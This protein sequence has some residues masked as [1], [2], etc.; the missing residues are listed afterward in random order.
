MAN[1]LLYQPTDVK[2]QNGHINITKFCKSATVKEILNGNF[3]LEIELVY[4]PLLWNAIERESIIYA[5]THRGKPLTFRLKHLNKDNKTMKLT[6]RHIFWDLG[7]DLIEDI[8]VKSMTGDQA[9]KYILSNGQSENLWTGE[10]NIL[11]VRNCRI[12]REYKLDAL[13][14][15]DDN[16]FKNRWGGELTIDDFHIAIDKLRGNQDP[17]RIKWGKDIK[18]FTFYEDYS[19]ICTRAM[20]MGFDGLM[21]PE[22]Y[23][24]SPL[25]DKYSMVYIKKYKFEDIKLIKEDDANAT[26]EEGAFASPDE[27]YRE[28][29]RRVTEDI[30]GKQHLDE[31]SQNIRADMISLRESDQYRKYGFNRLEGIQLGQAVEVDISQYGIVTT[32]RCISIEYDCLKDRYIEVELGD[33]K[34][35]ES[36]SET[37]ATPNIDAQLDSKLEAYKSGMFFHRNDKLLKLNDTMNEVCFLTFGTYI[38]THLQSTICIIAEAEQ[39]G[40]A[41]LQLYID[42]TPM[43]VIPMQTYQQ[44]YFTWTITLPLLFIQ[45]NK[46]HYFSLR[47]SS[48]TPT[49]IKKDQLYVTIYGQAI[50]GGMGTDYPHAEVSEILEPD[51]FNH[52]KLPSTSDKVEVKMVPIIPVTGQ[53]KLTNPVIEVSLPQLQDKVS[54]SFMY[55]GFQSYWD[56]NNFVADG[57]YYDLTNSEKLTV[58]QVTVH[59]SFTTI[60]TESDYKVES[61]ELPSTDKYSIIQQI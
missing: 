24:D 45:S 40:V 25:L 30:Y 4:N 56:E 1:I 34:N 35:S 57:D 28:M 23:V 53:N 14:G 54:H 15:K 33:F 60:K 16:S 3:L 9:I 48:T 32:K 61:C 58:K 37:V 2:R 52:I 50:S 18:G 29:R 10:S 22:K 13:M 8:F 42:N 21:L 7:N 49:I 17:V 36:G 44:G 6:C 41:T 26:P 47:L 38:N 5:P 43:D 55:K 19:T 27:A 31:P 12:V 51:M 20:P 59:N 46:A 39:P 11:D